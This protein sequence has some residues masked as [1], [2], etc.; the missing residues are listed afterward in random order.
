MKSNSSQASLSEFK[1]WS[2]G[3]QILEIVLVSFCRIDE[4]VQIVNNLWTRKYRCGESL[5]C[6]ERIMLVCFNLLYLWMP[7]CFSLARFGPAYYIHLLNNGEVGRFHT[8][9]LMPSLSSSRSACVCQ[10]GI[11]WKIIGK[12][13][14]MTIPNPMKHD[15]TVNPIV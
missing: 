15:T 7:S 9:P 3:G 4:T 8:S 1:L 5:G 14:A 2:S 13:A 10:L 6:N 11:C 12:V